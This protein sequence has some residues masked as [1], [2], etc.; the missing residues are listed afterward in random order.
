VWT[1]KT[2]KN[3]PRDTREEINIIDNQVLMVLPDAPISE[4]LK[5][6]RWFSDM[7]RK[8]GEAGAIISRKLRR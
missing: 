2:L 5:A 8:T 4:R 3:W 1:K 7:Q 6:T